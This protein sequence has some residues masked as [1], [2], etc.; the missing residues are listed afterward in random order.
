MMGNSEKNV[1]SSD[2]V[3]TKRTLGALLIAL[4]ALAFV[5]VLLLDALRGSFGDFGPTQLLALAGSLGA[6][7]IGLSLLP[8]GDR[9]A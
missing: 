1:Q 9:P 3:I 4:G 2:F 5:A 7:L 6:C 8:L